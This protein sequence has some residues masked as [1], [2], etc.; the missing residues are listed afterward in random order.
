LVAGFNGVVDGTITAWDYQW[1]YSCWHNNGLAIIPRSNLIS[2]VGFES[3]A[4][5]TR[6]ES[7]R[8]SNV[9]TS[10]VS[11]PL[12]HPISIA[13]NEP[14]DRIDA[15]N[16]CYGINLKLPGLITRGIYEDGWMGETAEVQLS[17][18]GPISVLRVTGL[19]PGIGDTPL[20]FSILVDGKPLAVRKLDPGDFEIEL[21]VR[22]PGLHHVTLLADLAVPLPP[23]DR[24]V[25]S[26]LLHTIRFTEIPPPAAVTKFPGDLKQPG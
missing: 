12:E 21:Q 24:R 15:E 16:Q 3:R 20:S 9:T 11:F 17:G 13:R 23:P 22:D 2:N 18:G 25:V 14:L 8:W 19:R 1:V 5:N 6:D 4:T 7:H 10:D 26:V